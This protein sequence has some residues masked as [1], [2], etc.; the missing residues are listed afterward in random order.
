M[1]DPDLIPDAPP[2]LEIERDYEFDEGDVGGPLDTFWARGHGHD[3]DV[4]IRAV[5]ELCLGDGTVPRIDHDDVLVHMWQQNISIG[6]GIEYRRFSEKP[7]SSRH[8]PAFPVTVLDL[9]RRRLGGRRCMFTDCKMPWQATTPIRV[10]IGEGLEYQAVEISTCREHRELLPDPYYRVCLV[11]VGAT[12]VLPPGAPSPHAE[13][14]EAVR[15][16]DAEYERVCAARE[17]AG[18]AHDAK[19]KAR[20]AL[21]DAFLAGVPHG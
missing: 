20:V 21:A 5:I 13:L 4:F 11:P 18:R 1:A 2:T 15:A 8:H 16:A 7:E 17:H 12:V 3:P 9:N 19:T 10:V 6:D 14:I